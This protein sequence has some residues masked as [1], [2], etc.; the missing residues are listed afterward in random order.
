MK[1][2]TRSLLLIE[3]FLEQRATAQVQTFTITNKAT[4]FN[5]TITANSLGV[6]SAPALASG[7]YEVHAEATGFRTLLRDATVQAGETTTVNPGSASA[8]SWKHSDFPPPVGRRAKTSLPAN[9]SW[10]ISACKGRKASKPKCCFSAPA[11]SIQV[12]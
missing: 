2:I 1:K 10:M 11:E 3:R 8:G 12:F 4:G 6:Y 7:E 5:R 9:A